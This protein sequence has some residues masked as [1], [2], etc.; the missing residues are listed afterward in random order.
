[1]N[2]LS[3]LGIIVTLGWWKLFKVVKEIIKE[4]STERGVYAV[5]TSGINVKIDVWSTFFYEENYF[6]VVIW[7]DWLIVRFAITDNLYIVLETLDV[8]EKARSPHTSRREPNMDSSV[9]VS[10]IRKYIWSA[11]SA[12][13]LTNPQRSSAR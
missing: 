1:M 13:S 9:G 10:R 11:I 8:L 3:P 4:I 5:L 6:A 2:L 12:L 7:N